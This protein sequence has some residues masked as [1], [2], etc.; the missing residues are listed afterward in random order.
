MVVRAA[1]ASV[2][3]LRFV[4]L[5]LLGLFGRG[6]VQWFAVLACG[7]NL[8]LAQLVWRLWLSDLLGWCDHWWVAL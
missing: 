6:G 4:P 5:G 3:A 8:C 7:C 1:A 2:R